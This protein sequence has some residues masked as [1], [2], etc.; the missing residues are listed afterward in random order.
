MLTENAGFKSLTPMLTVVLR[1]AEPGSVPDASLPS[2]MTC[3]NYV[4]LPDYSSL[5]VMRARLDIAVKEGAGAFH[6][7]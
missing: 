4:K 5:E 1:P 7:S 2:V 3:Q 6:L